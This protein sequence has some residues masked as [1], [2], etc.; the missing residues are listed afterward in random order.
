MTDIYHGDWSVIQA[1][2]NSNCLVCLTEQQIQTILIITPLLRL[3]A[4]WENEPSQAI[5]NDFVDD[6]E[7]RLITSMCINFRQNPTNSCKLQFTT[8]NGTTRTDIFDYSLCENNAVGTLIDIANNINIALGD[9][10]TVIQN[11]EINNID[12]S[13]TGD[14]TTITNYISYGETID[15][16]DID[17]ALCLILNVVIRA[18]IETEIDRR[19]NGYSQYDAIS[20]FLVTIG[21]A[22]AGV[23]SGY[24]LIVVA[25][26]EMLDVVGDVLQA[27]DN[28][29]LNDGDVIDTVVCDIYHEM[30]NQTLTE[31]VW[32]NAL[33][34]ISYTPNSPEQYMLDALKPAFDTGEQLGL[35]FYLSFLT[36]FDEYAQIAKYGSLPSCL[37]E[38][39]CS[40]LDFRTGQQGYTTTQEVFNSPGQWIDTVG[41]SAT[42]TSLHPIGGGQ[43]RVVHIVDTFTEQFVD[44]IVMEYHYDYGV[45]DYTSGTAISIIAKNNGTT[46]ASIIKTYGDCNTG[47]Y[48]GDNRIISLDVQDDIDEIQMIL[49]SAHSP[50]GAPA[51]LGTAIIQS[52][53]ISC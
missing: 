26:G 12:N 50:A 18:I 7:S 40:N 17:S 5:L 48:D 51:Q 32:N 16:L 11:D 52:V 9:I 13:Y 42:T 49:S 38:D 44:R 30:R 31:T 39:I 36:Q 3:L 21:T 22:L 6:I 46:V 2:Q 43:Y 33:D 15:D 4:R 24:S 25:L 19:L 34:N 45:S 23:T 14:I 27:V 10:N 53:R 28:T 29:V 41:W 47:A 8:D 20:T 37:C 1:K 35:N